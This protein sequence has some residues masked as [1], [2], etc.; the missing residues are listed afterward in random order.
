MAEGNYATEVAEFVLDLDAIIRI[1]GVA[2]DIDDDAN[3]TIEVALTGAREKY[4]IH[5]ESDEAIVLR[6]QDGSYCGSSMPV[7]IQGTFHDKEKASINYLIALFVDTR[8]AGSF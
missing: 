6:Y 8:R 4:G 7:N 1:G 5:F 2:G 3:F